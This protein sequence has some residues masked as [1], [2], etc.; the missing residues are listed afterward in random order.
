MICIG[1]GAYRIQL[2]LYL[3]HVHEIGTVVVI[4]PQLGHELL[5]GICLQDEL[6]NSADHILVAEFI[7]EELE[8][9]E[10][11]DGDAAFGLEA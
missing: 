8:F 4:V 11:V 2:G 6:V 10:V 7:V 1:V 3:D 9:T 5:F